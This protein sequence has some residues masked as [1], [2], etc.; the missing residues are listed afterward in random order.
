MTCIPV[1]FNG[2]PFDGVT[3]LDLGECFSWQDLAGW[4]D[5]GDLTVTTAQDPFG[6]TPTAMNYGGR[7]ITLTGLIHMPNPNLP[8]GDIAWSAMRFIKFLVAP[9]DFGPS[10]LEVDE[11]GLVGAPTG[12][13]ALCILNGPIR[14]KPTPST[15]GIANVSFQVPLL[16]PDPRRYSTTLTQDT[17]LSCSGTT[18]DKTMVNNGDR[19]SPF[20]ATIIGDGVNPYIRSE[21]VIGNPFVQANVTM[22]G[23]DVLIIDMAQLTATLNGLDVSTLLSGPAAGPPAWWALP[24]GSSIVRLGRASGSGTLV[25]EVDYRDSYS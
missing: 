7:T 23:G 15:L 5:S 12:L 13:Q 8:L 22:V 1:I 25:A 11:T 20:L 19:P 10:L 6:V 16:A 18:D 4:F 9:S 2:V 17:Q 14:M 24:A 21:T 3:P